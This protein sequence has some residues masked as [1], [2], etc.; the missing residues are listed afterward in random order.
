VSWDQR[1]FDPITLPDRKP[2]VTLRDAA[3]Y[4]TEPEAEHNAD[5]W[6]AAMQRTWWACNVRSHRRHE[7]HEPSRRAGVQSVAERHAL[8]TA[9]AKARHVMTDPKKD[10]REPTDNKL[11]PTRTQSRE[12]ERQRIVEEYVIDLREILKKL[13]R[14]FN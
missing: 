10:A 3:E 1:F 9:Q 8:G 7:S 11:G 12:A 14:L 6:Q 2:L 13:R 5:E 4:I